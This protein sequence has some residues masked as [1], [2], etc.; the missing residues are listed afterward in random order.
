MK[1]EQLESHLNRIRGIENS[2]K[3]NDDN[4]KL[5]TEV[6]LRR[7]GAIRLD[8]GTYKIYQQEIESFFR[9]YDSSKK[10]TQY[11]KL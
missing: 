8:D 1:D 10:F 7:T 6:F 9:R 4:V 11:D 3:E 2:L 5:I